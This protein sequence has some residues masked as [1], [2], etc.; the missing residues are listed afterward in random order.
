M[1]NTIENTTFKTIF[2]GLINDK[3][4]NKKLEIRVKNEAS[5]ILVDKIH[6]MGNPIKSS[7]Y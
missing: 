4:R 5:E 6:Q 2:R 3:P 1:I 7:K